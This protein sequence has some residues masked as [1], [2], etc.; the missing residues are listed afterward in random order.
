MSDLIQLPEC[1][2]RHILI[3]IDDRGLGRI[4]LGVFP[5]QVG[6]RT[7]GQGRLLVCKDRHHYDLEQGFRPSRAKTATGVRW[8][9]CVVTTARFP[10]ATT[11]VF[12]HEGRAEPPPLCY[13]ASMNVHVSR[14]AAP[15]TL[16]AEGLPR[17]RWSVADIERMQDAGIVDRHER[18]EL[19]GGEIVP[20]SPK[21][22]WHENVKRALNIH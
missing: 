17:R 5:Q 11:P 16:T 21:G 12:H 13:A 20:M 19:I 14:P 15:A 9:P 8:I 18:F 7:I 1:D 10:A 22:S 6:D 3:E 2:R 4:T